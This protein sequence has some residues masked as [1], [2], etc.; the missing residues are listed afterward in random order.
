L[1][2]DRKKES[3]T[4]GITPFCLAKY[5]VSQQLYFLVMNENP[6]VFQDPMRPVENISWTEATLFCNT[7]SSLENRTCFYKFNGQGEVEAYDP[8]ADG[9]R[10]PT[11]GEWE[12]ACKAGTGKIRY[13]IW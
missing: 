13:V 6:S 11:E 7:L 10:L 5:P 4:V 3:W 9:Y 2:D 12:Y 8:F 1:R